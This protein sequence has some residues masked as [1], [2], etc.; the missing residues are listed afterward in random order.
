MFCL[1]IALLALRRTK[2][3]LDDYSKAIEINPLNYE[4]YNNRGIL[5]IILIR[6]CLDYL[7][8][9]EDALDDYS[10]AIKFIH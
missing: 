4:I 3:A 9:T 5:F 1:G 7:E 10:K 8:R 2:E 6:K